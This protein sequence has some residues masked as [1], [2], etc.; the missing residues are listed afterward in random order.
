MVDAIGETDDKIDFPLC[1]KALKEI[2]KLFTFP[3]LLEAEE[4]VQNERIALPEEVLRPG[5]LSNSA[6]SHQA[7]QRFM[8]SCLLNLRR[9]MIE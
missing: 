1:V 3:C 5:F 4:S 6:N 7:T 2:Y 8:L 9:K